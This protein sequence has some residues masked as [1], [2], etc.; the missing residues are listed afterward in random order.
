MM[1]SILFVIGTLS[2][3][4]GRK[5]ETIGKKSENVL[6]GTRGASFNNYVAKGYS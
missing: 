6:G 5:P 1:F 3:L 2:A 4:S